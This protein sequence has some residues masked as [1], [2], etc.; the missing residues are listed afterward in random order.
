MQVVY[1]GEDATGVTGLLE[2]DAEGDVGLFVTSVDANAI[3]RLM[4]SNC[5]WIVVDHSFESES[6][7]SFLGHTTAIDQDVRIAY[8]GDVSELSENAR[9][10]VDRTLSPAEK[11]SRRDLDEG[12]KTDEATVEGDAV[13]AGDRS[14]V[15]P[16]EVRTTLRQTAECIACIDRDGTYRWVNEAMAERVGVTNA[17]LDETSVLEEHPPHDDPERVLD[18]GR[19]ALAEQRVEQQVADVAEENYQYFALPIDEDTFALVERDLNEIAAQAHWI[20]TNNQFAR[21]ILNQLDDIFFVNDF[22]GNLI[23]WNDRLNEVT[24]YSDEELDSMLAIELF[25][26]HERDQ[27]RKEMR[28]THEKGKHTAELPLETKDGKLIPYEFSGSLIQQSHGATYISGI[29]RDISRRVAA[30]AELEETVRQLEQSNAALE[31]FA[32]VA[33]H[34]LKEP[35]R[36]VRGYLNMFQRRHGDQLD[37]D[38]ERLVQ[39]AADGADRMQE[40]IE[41]LLEYSRVGTDMEVAVVD[42]EEVFRETLENLRSAIVE[43]NARISAVSLPQVAGDRK[44]LVRLFQN[45]LS[46]AIEN[47]GEDVPRVTISADRQDDEWQFAVHDEGIGM[48]EAEKNDVFELFSSGHD[49]S[50]IGLATCEKIVDYHDGEIWIDSEKHVGTTFY[51][52][53]PAIDEN[54]GVRP[55]ETNLPTDPQTATPRQNGIRHD[56]PS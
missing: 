44:M 23:H 51:F 53:L 10:Y 21:T 27:A 46:N 14:S 6:L 15:L 16:S 25:P 38:A 34:D 47:S 28:R 32:Y 11:I 54:A 26:E 17:E 20:N 36:S 3:D 31:E 35:L 56:G 29:A 7:T 9:E 30:E 4:Q 42:C 1:L 22:D 19:A 39:V 12:R 49:S 37:E 43:S 24:G 8:R 18:L 52:T 2:G 33:S 41:Q 55:D 5:D 48:T 50:G 40:M 13:D 45:L